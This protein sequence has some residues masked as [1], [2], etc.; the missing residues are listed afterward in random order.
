MQRAPR[1]VDGACAEDA[2][3]RLLMQQL[4]ARHLG[5]DIEAVCVMCF[6]GS[7]GSFEG[8][9]RGRFMD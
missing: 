4:K 6:H 5:E 1:V 2:D 9:C 7:S 8:G 3:L